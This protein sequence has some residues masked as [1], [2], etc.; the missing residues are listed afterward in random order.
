MVCPRCIMVVEMLA[1]RLNID[2]AYISLGVLSLKSEIS[3]GKINELN[4]ELQAI[5]FE[6]LD[7]RSSMITEQIKNHI[8]ELVHR[9]DNN[10]K[11]NLSDY[12]S[13]KMNHD[14]AYLTSL[15]SKT[16]GTTIEK[17]FIANK[18]ERVKELITY[19]NMSLSEIAYMLNYSSAA[20]L[21]SQFKKVTGIT[22]SSYKETIRKK[23]KSLDDV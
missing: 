10:I 19:D 9:K 18:I 22:P 15:F 4:H 7:N 1:K 2:Y 21:S 13:L 5:G 8:R 12:L 14:Y 23:R 3:E 6:V 20:H 11:T 16:E 17:Y